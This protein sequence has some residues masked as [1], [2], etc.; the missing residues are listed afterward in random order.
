MGNNLEDKKEQTELN[1][2]LKTKEQPKSNSIL[3]NIKSTFILKLIFKNIKKN[4][5]FKIIQIN[6]QI[7]KRLDLGLKEYKELS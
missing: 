1:S 6:K 4:K 2:F 5:L 3:N 7:Q